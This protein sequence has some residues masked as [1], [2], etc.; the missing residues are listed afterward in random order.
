MW[1][2]PDKKSLFYGRS[3]LEMALW[4]KQNPTAGCCGGNWLTK[5]E[6]RS[7]EGCESGD[8]ARRLDYAGRG[9]KRGD[10]FDLSLEPT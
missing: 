2:R 9:E 7:W 3:I 10:R 6:G 1:L 8:S 4:V 5:N